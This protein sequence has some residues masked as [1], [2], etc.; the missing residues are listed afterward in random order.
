M[1]LILDSIFSPKLVFQRIISYEIKLSVLIEAIIFIALVNAIF[2]YT[3]NYLIYSNN[4]DEENLFF[5]Y[6]E[7]VLKKPLLLV[8]LEIFKILF[9]TS[10]ITYLGKVFGGKGSFLNLLKCVIWIHFILIFINIILFGAIFLN[11]YISSYLIM[12]ANIWI[13][14]VLSECATKAHSFKSTFLVFIVGIIIL[15]ILITLL[16][17]VL[18]SSDIVFLERVS[19]N[20]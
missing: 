8:F 14:W 3:S 9:I 19:S 12:L 13:L 1:K 2:T 17:Q 6:Y 4:V 20:V 10:V 18:N 15:V 5:L 7:N 16:L 11:I